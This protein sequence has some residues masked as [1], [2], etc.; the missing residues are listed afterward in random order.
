MSLPLPPANNAFLDEKTK[1]ASVRDVKMGGA[2]TTP[3]QRP[4]DYVA[5]S[6]SQIQIDT[7]PTRPPVP[8]PAKKYAKTLR[9][10]SDQLVSSTVSVVQYL[11]LSVSSR[12][13]EISQLETWPKLNYILFICH[14]S[15]CSN[16]ADIR[17]GVDR[18][19]PHI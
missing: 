12:N 2:L 8:T 13:S 14:W 15:H 7:T 3:N 6:T 16:S 19:G 18:S 10:T 1:S 11:S 9:L 5:S 4:A 17:M